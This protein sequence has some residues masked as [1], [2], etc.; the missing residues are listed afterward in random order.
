M[1]VIIQNISAG[2]LFFSLISVV[3]HVAAKT[4]FEDYIGCLNTDQHV[5]FNGGSEVGTLTAPASSTFVTSVY[6]YEVDPANSAVE[7][8]IAVQFP[9]QVHSPYYYN[10]SGTEPPLGSSSVATDYFIMNDVLSCTAQHLDITGLADEITSTGVTADNY[11][12][13]ADTHVN[14]WV[15]VPSSVVVPTAATYSMADPVAGGAAG[16]IM[17]E[18]TCTQRKKLDIRIPKTWWQET[19][20]E[21]AKMKIVFPDLDFPANRVYQNFLVS[22]SL[23]QIGRAHV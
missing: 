7:S 3:H 20:T 2:Q 12:D 19:P 23:A 6:D 9:L 17:P 13:Y 14:K 5:Y 16:W 1:R 4:E 8:G 21:H 10:G 18:D 11:S 15:D 22:C